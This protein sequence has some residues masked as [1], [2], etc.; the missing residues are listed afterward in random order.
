V[1]KNVIERAV[2]ARRWRF[3]RSSASGHYERSGRCR[4]GLPSHSFNRTHCSMLPFAPPIYS[5]SNAVMPQCAGKKK[6]S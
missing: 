1:I 2:G 4:A 5:G 3:F 6:D